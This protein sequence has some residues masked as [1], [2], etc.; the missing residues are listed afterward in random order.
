M[1]PQTKRCPTCKETLPLIFFAKDRTKPS[2]YAACCKSCFN[3][4]AKKSWHD[5]PR[6]AQQDKH[7]HKLTLEKKLF[8]RQYFLEHP[9]VD[10]GETDPLV[11]EFDHVRGEK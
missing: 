10:C 7:R 6:K 4:R 1:K 2:G 11:L 8:V 5:G 3:A 9:C